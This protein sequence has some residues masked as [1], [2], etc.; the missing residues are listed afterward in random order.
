MW[1]AD[2]SVGWHFTYFSDILKS[3]IENLQSVKQ[4]KQSPPLLVRE[5]IPLYRNQNQKVDLRATVL[6]KEMITKLRDGNISA[7]TSI[8]SAFYKDLVIF[9]AR[10]TKDL[11]SAEEIVQDTFVH[12]WEEHP[13]ININTSLK[14]YLLKTVNN[15]CIDWY[16]HKKVIKE[17]EDFVLETSIYYEFDTEN[18]VLH[19]ELENKIEEA[20]ALLP[21]E[22]SQTF[23]MNRFKGLKYQEIAELLGVSVRTI[24]V[25][26]GKT[27]HLLRNHLREYFPLI[28]S[29]AI[30]AYPFYR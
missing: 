30:A 25:R 3:M 28:I 22:I 19:S 6:E 17:H 29:I 14:S 20:L 4:K 27:L 10:F 15:K 11:N 13:A 26:I 21:D 7:F 8:F 1:N 24:E 5:L 9:A 2:Q 12:L 16:R 18:Y 23:R